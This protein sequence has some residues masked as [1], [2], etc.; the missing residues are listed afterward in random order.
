MD[1]SWYVQ[2]ILGREEGVWFVVVYAFC[3]YQGFPGLALGTFS[4]LSNLHQCVKKV[5]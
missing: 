3:C 2:P 4:S 5:Q 1:G